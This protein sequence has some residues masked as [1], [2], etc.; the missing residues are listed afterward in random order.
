MLLSCNSG[1]TATSQYSALQPMITIL[2]D[3]TSITLPSDNFYVPIHQSLQIPITVVGGNIAK[4]ESLSISAYLIQNQ[5]STQAGA[6]QKSMN[7]N[8][9]IVSISPDIINLY[10]Q[11][12]SN[13]YL[14]FDSSNGEV[15]TYSIQISGDYLGTNRLGFSIGIIVKVRAHKDNSQHSS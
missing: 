10:S 7:S 15:G 6:A 8:V 4:G 1:S 5:T 12:T 3:G 2:P 9:P 14:T 11:T 13:T